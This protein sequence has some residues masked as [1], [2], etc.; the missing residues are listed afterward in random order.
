MDLEITPQEV[1]RLLDEGAALALIDVRELFEYKTS[2]I[3]GSELMPMNTV[4]G[5]LQRLEGLADE[6]KLI[7]FCHHGIRSL[8]VVNWLRQRGVDNC[9]SMK[10]GIDAW[11]RQ[12]DPLIPLY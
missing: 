9:Q 2:C 3:E 11:G 4:P 6:K 12:I 1:K 5:Q 8:S 7:V 10:G